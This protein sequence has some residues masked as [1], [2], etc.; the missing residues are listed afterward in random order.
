MPRRLGSALAL[1]ALLVGLAACGDDSSKSSAP[2]PTPDDLAGASVTGEW[3]VTLTIDTQ[4]P[5]V[6]DD[7]VKAGDTLTRQYVLSGGCNVDTVDCE[8]RRQSAA[9]ESTEV[10]T[11][12]GAKLT[13]HNEAPVTLECS[14]DGTDTPV[15]YTARVTFTLEVT[16]AIQV[17]DTWM[18]TE[19][20]YKRNAELVPGSAAAEKGCPTGTQTESGTGVPAQSS[21]ETTGVTVTTVASSTTGS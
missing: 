21:T 19:L 12:T 16:D 20:D 6:L 3:T 13:Y 4:T 2:E 10:W 8:V 9:G 18:A 5:P 17:G 7:S 11:R 15:D 1:V 14:I